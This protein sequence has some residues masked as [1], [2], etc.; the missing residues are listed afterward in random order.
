MATESGCPIVKFT[1]K[2]LVVHGQCQT[3][4]LEGNIDKQTFSLK[5]IV[6][7]AVNILC[8]SISLKQ[9]SIKST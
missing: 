8:V 3:L 2:C 5:K 6:Y 7:L 1:W 9:D 4:P